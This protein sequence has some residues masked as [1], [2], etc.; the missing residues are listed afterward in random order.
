MRERKA[1]LAAVVIM[2]II[3]VSIYAVSTRRNPHEISTTTTTETMKKQ[4]INLANIP[5]KALIYDSLAREFPD[6]QQISEIKRLLEEAGFEVTVYYGVNATLD[7]LVAMGKYGIVILRAHGAYN[8]DPNSGEP[9]G[10]YVYTG[11]YV[12]E[13]QAIYGTKTIKDGFDKGYY[14]PAVI[15]RPGVPVSK[16]PKYLAVSP[17]FFKDLAGEMNNT[18]I[19]YTGCFGFTDD[20]LAKT[21]LSRG[22]LAYIAWTGNVTWMHSDQFLVEWVKDLVKTG[23]PLSALQAANQTVGP[24][25]TSNSVIKV[26]VRNGG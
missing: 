14:A 17:K 24:D 26:M 22:A 10:T 13:A 18:I 3:L 21:M 7:P 12:I 5:H 8:G 19:F 23:D 4:S 1:A 6:P 9:L 2:V 15:P 11:L 20:R 16:L 25:E